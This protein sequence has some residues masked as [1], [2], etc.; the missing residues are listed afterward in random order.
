MDVSI[1]IQIALMQ[2]NGNI[3]RLIGVNVA[4]TYIFRWTISN[5][6]SDSFDE[7]NIIVSPGSVG[8]GVTCMRRY[9]KGRIQE[10]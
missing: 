9:V 7:V 6:R 4:G 1:R 5:H 2:L 10:V 8:G 3:L